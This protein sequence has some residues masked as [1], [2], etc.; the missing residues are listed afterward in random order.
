MHLDDFAYDL[1]RELIADRPLEQRERARLMVLPAAGAIED[2][3]IADLP[4]LLRPGDLLVCND[5]KVVPA[6]LIGRRG[7][8]TVEL[9]LAQALGGGVWHAFAKGARRLKP[10]DRVE[11]ADDFAAE[12]IAKTAEGAI[13]LRFDREGE[14][15][16]AALARHGAMPLPPYIRRPRG[17][18]PRDRCDYQTV[19]AREEGAVAA[20]TAG[21]HFTPALLDALA[22]RGIERAMVTLHI[23][24]GTFLPVKTDDPREHRMHAERGHVDADAA[25]QINRARER[26]GRIV[27]IGTTSLRVLETAAD[28]RGH[29][30]PFR[31]E[32]RLFI[33]PGYRF[34]AIDLLLTNFHLPRSTLLMLVAALAGLDR[35]K[36]AYAHA[37]AERYRFFSYGDACLIEPRQ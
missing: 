4:A 1:P 24:P 9:T 6:R 12:I 26:G 15:F 21:L 34:R 10:G 22:G 32:T 30:A 13:E 31:G 28:A 20:H 35:I 19:F 2:R 36:A 29:I 18:D 14:A 27:A 16:R 8:A 3:H 37:V 25:A 11:F 5:T 7:A 17:G 23:G 33:L